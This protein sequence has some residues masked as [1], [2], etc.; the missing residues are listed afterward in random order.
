MR[1]ENAKDPT[2]GCLTGWRSPGGHHVPS[3]RSALAS[4]AVL[5]RTV[6][7]GAHHQDRVD[8]HREAHLRRPELRY[9]RPVREAGR[10]R[11]RRGEPARPAQHHHPGPRERAADR[12]GDGRVH[13]RRLRH[14]A[15]RHDEGQQDAF[16]Q[17]AQPRQQRRVE[18]I[19]PRHH[20]HSRVRR[21]RAGRR[22]RWLPAEP[23]LHHHLE[24]LAAG[25]AGRQLPHDRRG[26][27]GAQRGWI[28][29]HRRRPRRAEA[30][31]RRDGS[32][33]DDHAEPRRRALHRRH[34][35]ELRDGQHGQPHPRERVRADAD[36]ALACQ[37]PAPAD[38]QR[39]VVLR[40][41]LHGRRGG[42]ERDAD[43]L[44]A[45]VPAWRALRAH[46]PGEGPDR[47]RA[48]LGGGARPHLLLQAQPPRRHRRAESA[49]RRRTG[50]P[51]R[52]RRR[53]GRRR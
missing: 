51:R 31:P 42:A 1:V 8:A 17:R 13:G 7:A 25:R 28:V 18:H 44:P 33:G 15:D 20:R 3:S 29:H 34:P 50:P 6:R 53:W 52:R 45:Q 32:R 19:Q 11:L 40:L 38:L 36:L 41:D 24:R 10:H 16:L 49:L 23:G 46:L 27:G 43:L 30:G 47:P 14:Q 26:A 48:G 9:R 39:P 35:R 12:A 5:P 21:E 22:G 4:P 2:D 37:R